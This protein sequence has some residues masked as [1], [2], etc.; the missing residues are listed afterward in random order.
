MEIRYKIFIALI[1]L[2]CMAERL[3]AQEPLYIVNGELRE[4]ISSIDPEI[5]ES[6]DVLPADETTIEKY[7][8]EAGNGV[9]IVTL[10]YDVEAQF[11]SPHYENFAEYII[12]S[13]EW[14]DNDPTAQV[15]VRITINSSGV[16]QIESVLQASDKR[17]LRRVVKAI[18]SSPRWQ[19]AT[20]CGEAV[21]QHGLILNITLPIGREMPRERYVI[22]L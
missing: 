19:P 16:P 9:V 21:T 17:L 3:S 1:S 14:Q 15:V 6:L 11:K 10:K 13:V 22:I 8:P 5:I 7:G 4:E 20:K 18:E 2:L 12:S